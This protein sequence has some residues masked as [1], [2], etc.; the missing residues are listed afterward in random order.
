MRGQQRT[1]LQ[2]WDLE[3]VLTGQQCFF[4]ALELEYPGVDWFNN[5]WSVLHRVMSLERRSTACRVA[6]Q[7]MTCCSLHTA[8]IRCPCLPLRREAL[9]LG[10][11]QRDRNT[12][13]SGTKH[14]QTGLRLQIPFALALDAAVSRHTKKDSQHWPQLPHPSIQTTCSPTNRICTRQLQTA[15]RHNV[16]GHTQQR[17]SS[18]CTWQH[19]FHG[20]FPASRPLPLCQI[21]FRYQAA[22]LHIAKA[23]PA[24]L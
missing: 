16:S 21:E 17:L 9:R 11:G 2:R 23:V 8:G 18:K 14:I 6:D 15:N 13:D 7:R 24:R 3:R 10:H 19:P 4:C 22:S 12:H 5:D 20:T 1:S